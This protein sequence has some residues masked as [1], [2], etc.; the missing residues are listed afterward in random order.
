MPNKGIT[1]TS[2]LDIHVLYLVE[3]KP[4]LS[5]YFLLLFYHYPF[6]T[7]PFNQFVER[8]SEDVHG[9]Y[10]ICPVSLPD[11]LTG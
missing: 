7:L 6:R 8:A 5:P 4:H 11:I 10:F 2:K 9:E 1:L 3:K